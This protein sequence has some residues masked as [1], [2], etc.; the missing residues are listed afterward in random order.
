MSNYS[1]LIKYVT[2]NDTIHD[3]C[4]SER[5]KS[6]IYNY[7]SDTFQHII[8]GLLKNDFDKIKNVNEFN[9]KSTYTNIYNSN[10]WNKTIL[11]VEEKIERTVYKYLEKINFIN[12]NSGVNYFLHNIRK[13]NIDNN[14]KVEKYDEIKLNTYNF[15]KKKLNNNNDLTFILDNSSIFHSKDFFCIPPSILNKDHYTIYNGLSSL[16][17]SGITLDYNEN[18][19]DLKCYEKKEKYEYSLTK[20][21]NELIY[22]KQFGVKYYEDSDEYNMYRVINI[23]ENII[24][25]KENQDDTISLGSFVAL[26]SLIENTVRKSNEQTEIAEQRNNIINYFKKLTERTALQSIC[27]I[28]KITLKIQDKIITKHTND[29]I[30]R[31]TQKQ[32]DEKGDKEILKY[33]EYE[34]KELEN[35]LQKLNYDKHIRDFKFS[36]ELKL[37]EKKIIN[38]KKNNILNICNEI[39]LFISNLINNYEIHDKYLKD[40]IVNESLEFF[41]KKIQSNNDNINNNI[42]SKINHEMRFFFTRLFNLIVKYNNLTIEISNY[43]IVIKTFKIVNEKKDYSYAKLIPRNFCK[44]LIDFKRSMDYLQVKACKEF[45]NKNKNKTCVFVSTDRP[46]ILFSILNNCPTIKTTKDK[47]KTDVLEL[48]NFNTENINLEELINNFSSESNINSTQTKMRN[49]TINSQTTKENYRHN[50]GYQTEGVQES[51]EHHEFKDK[52]KEYFAYI[53]DPINTYIESK[54]FL[55]TEKDIIK[56]II[57]KAKKDFSTNKVRYIN[58]IKNNSTISFNKDSFRK[59][60]ENE[61]QNINIKEKILNKISKELETVE[62]SGGKSSNYTQKNYKPLVSFLESTPKTVLQSLP[63]TL[64]NNLTSNIFSSTKSNSTLKQ[65][66]SEL[67]KSKIQ[68]KTLKKLKSY[69]TKNSNSEYLNDS[70]KQ[71]TRTNVKNTFNKLN[72]RNTKTNVNNSQNTISNVNDQDIFNN[73]SVEMLQ[74]QFNKEVLFSKFLTIHKEYFGNEMSVFM[75][76]N[77]HTIFFLL[78]KIYNPNKDIKSFDQLYRKISKPITNIY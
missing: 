4:D 32:K 23:N 6:K 70:T 59:T 18:L 28:Y 5:N 34:K 73:I 57:K 45:N 75:Y 77:Y 30:T 11:N 72:T 35:R 53:N 44:C 1:N 51:N 63:K 60:L 27:D 56:K 16:Y 76:M 36:L 38:P 55:A 14:T 24:E 68:S 22:I 15:I 9:I 43:D 69:L 33:F 64:V 17:G 41:F 26:I 67:S 2:L 54:N 66:N 12:K 13:L 25:L 10:I 7:D 37:N 29:I 50:I 47:D 3:F 21:D 52:L 8:L 48:Y 78:D 42:N 20:N 19:I 39:V 31:L 71:K 62:Q 74:E 46:A 49:M 40:F 61:I 58:K 65:I